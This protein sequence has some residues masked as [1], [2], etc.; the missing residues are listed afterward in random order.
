MFF[1]IKDFVLQEQTANISAFGA[2]RKEISFNSY[3][4]GIITQTSSKATTQI[5][6]S[7]TPADLSLQAPAEWIELKE[8]DTVIGVAQGSVAN[9]TRPNRI[10]MRRILNL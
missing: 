7:T 9:S 4:S 3:T 8:G 1:L 6:D 2:R 5:Y 10:T